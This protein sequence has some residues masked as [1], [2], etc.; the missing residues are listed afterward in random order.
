MVVAKVLSRSCRRGKTSVLR[1]RTIEHGGGSSHTR[2]IN[3]RT[4]TSVSFPRYLILYPR[5]EVNLHQPQPH[6]YHGE[7]LGLPPESGANVNM[8]STERVPR[9]LSDMSRGLA[10]DFVLHLWSHW[11][12]LAG[13]DPTGLIHA[14]LYSI[15]ITRPA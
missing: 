6:Q 1:R 10:A 9:T 13:R 3:Q 12:R 4:S 15:P 11:G 14:S 8:L 7:S 2:C 5:T